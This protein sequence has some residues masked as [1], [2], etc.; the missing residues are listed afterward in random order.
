LLNVRRMLGSVPS[1]QKNLGTPLQSRKAMLET[2]CRHLYMVRLSAAG[3]LVIALVGCTGLV[4][5]G[6]DGMTSQQRDAI[7]K[8]VTTAMPVLS[9]DCVTCHNGSRPDV[10]FL[11]GNDAVAIH[12]TLMAFQ[13]PVVNL[14]AASSSQIVTKGLH[15]GPQLTADETSKILDWVFAE[16]DAANHNPDNPTTQLATKPFAVQ[17]CTA[18]DP[19]NAQGTCPTNH[20]SLVGL[21]TDGTTLA[22]AEIAFTAQALGDSSVYVT[23]LVGTGGTSGFYL[24]HLLFVSRPAMAVPFPDQ[25]DRYYALKLN[26]GPNKSNPINGGTEDFVGF[27][28]TDMLEIHFKVLTAF[29]PDTTG[30]KQDGCK[31]LPSFKTN[32]QPSLRDAVGGAAQKCADCHAG[33]NAGATGAMDLSKI[34]ATTDADILLA[35]NQV[36][37]RINFQTTD[38]SGFY[39]APNPASATNHPFKLTAAQFTTFKTAVDVWVKAEQTAP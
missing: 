22:G 12:D 9:Q 15:E 36:R 1:V 3:A 33:S 38:Q 4:D 21:P 6:S 26:V 13:P 29:K 8:W 5:G 2:L 28:P 7:Q 14:D 20:V 25:I 30:S 27:H 17:L 34:A 37:T 16:R 39:L 32:A 19:D 23:N 24:E 18:G 10:G 31:M 35:C 11:I